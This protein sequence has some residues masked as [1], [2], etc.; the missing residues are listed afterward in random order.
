M[1]DYMVEHKFK[2]EEMRDQYFEAMK[3]M[4]P[5]DVRKNMKNENA[6]FQM[7]WNNEKNDMVMYCWWKA[8]SPQA[9]LDTL[10]DMAGMFHNDIK[11][12]SNVMDVTDQ[13]IKSKDTYMNTH[14][15][16]KINNTTDDEWKKKIDADAEV[17][18]QMMRNSIV[19]K[20]DDETAIISTDV[21]NPEMVGQFMSSD[22]FKQMEKDLG[23]S[24]EV[25]QLTKN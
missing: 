15:I 17:Q 1:K 20:V 25:Y 16:V 3:D 2:S 21:F 24:H 4:T 11:E 9:I 5:D 12:M 7:N 18:S 22:E 14:I 10:G 6:N 19:G 23:L 13:I 8:N